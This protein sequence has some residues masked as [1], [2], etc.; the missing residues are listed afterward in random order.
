[1][2]S[3]DP[4]IT[5][6][7]GLAGR[8]DPAAQERLFRLV[9]GHLRQLARARMSRQRAPSN[10][11]TTVLVDDAFV[12]LVGSQNVT[13]ESRSQFYCFAA[14][15]MRQIS[16]DDARR[17]GA[18]KRGGGESTAPLDQVPEPIVRQ[19]LEPATLLALHEALDKLA[20]TQ[21]ELLPIVELRYFAGHDLTQI[22][23]IL[24]IPY[25]TV[26]RRWQRARALLLREVS[27]GD[28]DTGTAAP[29]Q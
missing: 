28:H 4:D 19:P 23:D 11:Q 16:A 29:R 14:R 27:G 8:G 18:R 5:M 1:M 12:R 25:T 9:E 26:K 17:R 6:L 10:L 22:A 15:V 2:P 20:T 24:D 7:L 21:P 13:W 3:P